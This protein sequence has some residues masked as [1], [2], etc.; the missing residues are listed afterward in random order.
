MARVL[1]LCQLD[2]YANQLKPVEVERFLRERGH[3]VQV[4]DTSLLSRSTTS[5]RLPG[6][7]ARQA[8]LFAVEG[9]ARLVRRHELTRRHLSHPALRAD[10]R[11][12]RGIL[13]ATLPLAGFDLV[14]CEEPYDAWV[15]VDAPKSLYDC[16]TPWADELFHE[17]RLTPRQHRAMRR[18]EARLFE[19]VDHLAFHWESYARYA[20]L[21]YGISGRNLLTLNFG[22]TPADRRA[23]FADPPRIAYL[24]SLGSRFIDLPLLARLSRRYPVDVYGGPPPDPALGLNHR[25]YAAPGILAEYQLGL[26][27][28]TR[29]EL[30]RE[31]F[32]AKHLEYLAHGLPVLVPAWRRGLGGLRG[33]VAYEEETFTEVVA[34]LGRAAEWQRLSDEAYAEAQRLAWDETLRPLEWLLG[35]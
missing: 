11:L 13:R 14:I 25:G 18:N 9:A 34:G 27:T 23:V 12:R 19:T 4:V 24:G 16:P 2:G 17:G 28:C 3:E 26:I 10:Q 32:S 30:R 15:L 21:H 8:A 31:G 33:S 20:K 7:S 22:C 35:D 5:R 29:D 6:R 1:L